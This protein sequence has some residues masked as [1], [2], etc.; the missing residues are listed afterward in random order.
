MP[1]GI[2]E[3]LN[4]PILA[5][6]HSKTSFSSSLK[7]SFNSLTTSPTKFSNDFFAIF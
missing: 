7:P 1:G 3:L 6:I 2:Y 4:L 5:L